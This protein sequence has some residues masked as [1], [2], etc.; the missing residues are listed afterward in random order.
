MSGREEFEKLLE[1]VFRCGFNAGRLYT[2]ENKVVN[3]DK[4]TVD[5]GVKFWEYEKIPNEQGITWLDIVKENEMVARAD[6]DWWFDIISG[7]HKGSL[8]NRA[9][10][11]TDEELARF[12]E[13]KRR[14]AT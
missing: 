10:L 4:L 9:P 6:L 11:L 3:I 5:A 2:F 7:T 13:H 14:Y 12:S 8:S 1:D